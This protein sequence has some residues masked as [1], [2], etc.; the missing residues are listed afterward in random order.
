MIMTD[1]PQLIV[2]YSVLCSILE[3][4]F[5]DLLFY[6]P[7]KFNHRT[8]LSQKASFKNV[9]KSLNPATQFNSTI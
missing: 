6:M 4:M 7:S 9:P 1:I 3:K 8:N 2:L 5:V